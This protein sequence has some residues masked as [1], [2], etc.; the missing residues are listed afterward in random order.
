MLA[1]T[2]VLRLHHLAATCSRPQ[3]TSWCVGTYQIV[4]DMN[5]IT[6][7]SDDAF[8][9]HIA[10]ETTKALRTCTAALL[11]MHQAAAT[12][13]AIDQATIRSSPAVALGAQI[14]LMCFQFIYSLNS[15]PC[16]SRLLATLTLIESSQDLGSWPLH[17]SVVAAR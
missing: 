15:L 5:S 1:N 8:E 7:E 16:V 6:R 10:C 4:F 2:R 11:G 17:W 9:W 12:P 3:I 13:Q 14:P